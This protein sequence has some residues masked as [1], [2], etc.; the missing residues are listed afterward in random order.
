MMVESKC[1]F[2]RQKSLLTLHPFK[3]IMEPSR[4]FTRLIEKFFPY[5]FSLAKLTH[6]SLFRFII[7]KMLFDKNNLT[8]LTKDSVV[9]IQL[10]KSIESFEN[11]AVP[12]KI[13]EY[14]IEQSSFRFIMDF[15]IC[16][17]SMQCKNYP[18][19]L[20]CLFMGEAAKKIPNELGRPVTVQDA[21]DHVKKCRDAG[22]VHLIGRDKLD[23]TWLGVGSSIPLVTVCNCCECCCLWR[24]RPYLDKNLSSTIKAMPGISIHVNSNC[25]GCGLCTENVCFIDNIAIKDGKAVI[26]DECVICGRC[27]DTCPHDAID[28]TIEDNDFINKTIERVKNATKN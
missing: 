24:M 2:K 23:E 13:V 19:E 7:S 21:L 27:S 8:Y 22:L 4:R 26:G 25:T 17:E 5:R 12:S 6:I 1:I 3:M 11:L 28:I 15:C 20:G 18:I 9:E 14:F 16:R 10:N